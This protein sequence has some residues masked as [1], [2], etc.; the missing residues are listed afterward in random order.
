MGIS[1]PYSILWLWPMMS[2]DSSLVIISRESADPRPSTYNIHK[3]L[4]T[5]T[6]SAHRRLGQ[7]LAQGWPPEKAR[8]EGGGGGVSERIFTCAIQV[9][10]MALLH[11]DNYPQLGHV[12]KVLNVHIPL[13]YFPANFE[14][15]SEPAL[16]GCKKWPKHLQK[17]SKGLSKIDT[18]NPHGD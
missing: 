8:G 12:L 9:A 15:R 5:H 6:C 13:R 10:V 17:G 14:R 11:C 7:N 1:A 4:V 3:C 18:L 16:H 2:A